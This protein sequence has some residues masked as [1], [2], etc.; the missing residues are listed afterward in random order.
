MIKWGGHIIMTKRLGL[1]IMIPWIGHDEQEHYQRMQE[2]HNDT[3]G[4]YKNTTKYSKVE[5]VSRKTL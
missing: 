5:V 1:Q 2:H 4:N 3:I